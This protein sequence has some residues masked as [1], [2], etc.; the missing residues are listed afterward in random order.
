MAAVADLA[1]E[2]F[3]AHLRA[4]KRMAKHRFAQNAPAR[5]P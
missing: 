4:P 1:V 5:K 3:Q 2:N